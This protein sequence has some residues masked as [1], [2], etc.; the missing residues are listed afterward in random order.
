MLSMQT[1]DKPMKG[2]Q[3]LF[4]TLVMLQGVVSGCHSPAKPAQ[5]GEVPDYM[6]SPPKPREGMTNLE[7]VGAQ[8]G[9]E[10]TALAKGIRKTMGPASNVYP[11]QEVMRDAQKLADCALAG[12][13]VTLR[14]PRDLA[15]GMAHKLEEAGLAVRSS[16]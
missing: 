11:E 13:K 5:F 3:L 7:I 8:P 2:P 9:M 10:R 16:E 12:D 6:L 15:K 4:P 1:I 14:V